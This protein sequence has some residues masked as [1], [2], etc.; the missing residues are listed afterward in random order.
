MPGVMRCG[1]LA[2]CAMLVGAPA[3]HAEDKSFAALLARAKAQAAAGHRWGPP[4]D[5]MTETVM[6]MIDVAGTATPEQ[7]SE[8][9]AFLE[10]DKS[11]GS[12]ARA[13]P[14]PSINAQPTRIEPLQPEAARIETA[15]SPTRKA[16]KVAVITPTMP[17]P[18]PVPVPE[19]PGSGG[20]FQGAPGPG[21]PGPGSPGPGI[22]GAGSRAALLFARGLEAEHNGNFSGA[23]RF[24]SSS[25]ELGDAAAARNLGRLYDPT[26]VRKTAVGGVDADPA[27]ARQWYERAVGLGDP[28]AG[29]LLQAL[30]A[31]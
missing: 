30:S 10:Q 20:A 22:P 5:N 26:Y 21:S 13:N 19:N 27:V 24:Y 8:L 9:S 12:A 31:R 3:G 16:P 28:E 11:A 18:V 29:P 1:L 25:A 23:R 4:G 17:S 15:P 2:V 14:K 7:L 6:R